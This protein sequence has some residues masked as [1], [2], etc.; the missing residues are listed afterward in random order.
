M[1]WKEAIAEYVLY[2]KMERGLSENSVKAYQRDLKLVASLESLDRSLLK[3][4]LNDLEKGVQQLA[5]QGRSARSQAR[6]ISSLRNFFSYLQL[7]EY[8]SDNPAELLDSPKLDQ[9]LPDYLE[10][11]EVV[12]LIE[13][14]DL[15]KPEG[16]RNIAILETLYG[17][18][19]R[20][21]ELTGLRLSD[22][23]FSEGVI[24]VWGKGNKA[25]W[26]P[27]NELAQKRIELYRTEIRRHQSIQKKAED[28]LFLNRRGGGLSRAMIFNIVKMAAEQAGVRKNISPHTFR[29][30]FA[31]HLV[32][33]GVD[34]RAV[35][36]MLG[37]ESITTT[38]IYTHLNQQTLRDTIMK[39]HPR[40]Q[41]S[42]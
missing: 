22:L 35:Q 26:V 42:N 28:I 10:E 12:A 33:N 24:R 39:Y 18:G 27:I 29:H 17:C 9:K 38:E 14:F 3:I 31:T 15:S 37:H 11:V 30:S 34:L 4:E 19:L 1:R 16:M 8:R 7:E 6:L 2:L 36:D 41:F 5:E 20:V 13:S 32:R 23:Y 40:N 25:R 21:S